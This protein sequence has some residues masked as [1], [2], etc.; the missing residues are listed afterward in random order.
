MQY[1]QN[2]YILV[3]DYD[4]N[5]VFPGLRSLPDHDTFSVK[6]SAPGKLKIGLLIHAGSRMVSL[7][8]TQVDFLPAVLLRETF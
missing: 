2:V 6:V 7:D 3:H 4:K 5:T 8:N 1:L